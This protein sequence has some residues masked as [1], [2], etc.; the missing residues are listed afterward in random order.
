MDDNQHVALVEINEDCGGSRVDVWFWDADENLAGCPSDLRRMI[1]KRDLSPYLV[2][3][4]VGNEFLKWAEGLEEWDDDCPPVRV[5]FYW[6]AARTF[7]LTATFVLKRGRPNK[8]RLCE[9]AQRVF[10]DATEDAWILDTSKQC[11]QG[12]WSMSYTQTLTVRKDRNVNPREYSEVFEVLLAE[13]VARV[14]DEFVVKEAVTGVV[15]GASFRFVDDD[16][17]D[18]G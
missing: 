13:F 9:L 12:K 18:P 16:V 3:E 6:H 8:T 1:E 2:P 10:D 11:S 17:V 5:M 4:E 15:V 14:E 7:T